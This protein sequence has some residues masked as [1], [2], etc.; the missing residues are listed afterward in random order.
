M[1][2]TVG[3]VPGFATSDTGIYKPGVSLSMGTLK[4]KYGGCLH[5]YLF[6]Q[7]VVSTAQPANPFR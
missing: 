2:V 1:F 3:L 7:Q 4:L 6:N 5:R